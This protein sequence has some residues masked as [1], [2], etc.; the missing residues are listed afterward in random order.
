MIFFWNRIIF[1]VAKATHYFA[2][3]DCASVQY[4]DW[5]EDCTNKPV[6]VEQLCSVSFCWSCHCPP[7]SLQRFLF[8]GFFTPLGNICCLKWLT[9]ICNWHSSDTKCCFLSFDIAL[10]GLNRNT[11]S[12]SLVMV[13]KYVSN[14]FHIGCSCHQYMSMRRWKFE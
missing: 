6:A 2:A 9:F 13:L 3:S 11:T 8:E 10:K 7:W 1:E 14:V 4:C 12:G 5:I